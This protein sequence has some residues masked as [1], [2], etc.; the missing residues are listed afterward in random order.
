MTFDNMCAGNLEGAARLLEAAGFTEFVRD[1]P[2]CSVFIATLDGS[3][4]VAA[5]AAAQ[6]TEPLLVEKAAYCLGDPR[7]RPRLSLDQ[8]HARLPA[9]PG[10]T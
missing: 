3:D 6:A 4:A 1:L 5:T 7:Y 2:R 10:A 9:V 8:F